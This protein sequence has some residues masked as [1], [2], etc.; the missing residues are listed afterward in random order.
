M[1][2]LITVDPKR[3][4]GGNVLVAYGVW[5]AAKIWTDDGWSKVDTFGRAVFGRVVEGTGN[6]VVGIQIMHIQGQ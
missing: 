1:L 3:V 4:A 5:R 6:A 2:R